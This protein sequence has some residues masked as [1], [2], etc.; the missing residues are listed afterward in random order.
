MASGLNLNKNMTTTAARTSAAQSQAALNIKNQQTM[1]P[2]MDFDITGTQQNMTM[3]PDVTAM[4]Y[5]ASSPTTYDAPSTTTASA[6]SI[7]GGLFS[8]GA[9]IVNSQAKIEEIESKTDRILT[10]MD[11]AVNENIAMANISNQQM[12]AVDRTVGDMMSA[13]GIARMKSEARLR[14]GAA[15]T[16]TSGGTTKT[17][18]MEARMMEHLDNAIVIARGRAEKTTIMNRQDMDNI[19]TRNRLRYMAS[20]IESPQMA[21]LGVMAAG[22][23]GFNAGYKMMPASERE[24]YFSFNS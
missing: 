6:G 7:V 13:N 9:A 2:V 10:A 22:F 19:S 1:M 16:G 21:A 18:T 11:G 17:A 12:L 20:G 23:S 24:K 4:S 5:D 8:V 15:E 14:A 3:D